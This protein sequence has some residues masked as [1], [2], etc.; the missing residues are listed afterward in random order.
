[1]NPTI[2]LFLMQ[3]L[4]LRSREGRLK[5]QNTVES[6][7]YSTFWIYQLPTAVEKSRVLSILMDTRG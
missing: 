4:A 7:D 1:V 2:A 3:F 5:E 6:I